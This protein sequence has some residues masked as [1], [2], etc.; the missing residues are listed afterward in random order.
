MLWRRADYGS[1]HDCEITVAAPPVI[2]QSEAMHASRSHTL[3][4]VQR[5]SRLILLSR[6]L[7]MEL[8][9]QLS[10]GLLWRQQL[11]V[12]IAVLQYKSI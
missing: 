1:R 4:V 6:S 10:E 3:C 8:V 11:A 9:G 2:Q 7:A 5:L 12:L